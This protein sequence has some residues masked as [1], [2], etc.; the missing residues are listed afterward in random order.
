MN[1]ILKNRMESFLRLTLKSP[2][3]SLNNGPFSNRHLRVSLPSG[4]NG[5]IT[6]LKEVVS[7]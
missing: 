5:L 7:E 2:M 3:I 6:T 1:Y 4:V